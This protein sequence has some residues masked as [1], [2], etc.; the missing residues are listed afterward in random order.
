MTVDMKTK[1]QCSGCSACV[2]ICPKHCISMLPDNEGFIYPVID[3]EKCVHCGLCKKN[4]PFEDDNKFCTNTH[5]TVLG[6]F[7]KNDEEKRKSSSG[8]IFSL[9]AEV[10]LKQNGIVFGMSL[11]DDCKTAHTISIDNNKEL[12][13]LRG[14]KYFQGEIDDSFINAKK[15]L[16]EGRVVLFSGTPCQIA[17]LYSFLGKKYDNLLTVDVVCHGVPSQLL[18][19]KYIQNDEQNRNS[20]IKSVNFRSKRISWEE[21]GLE[22]TFSDNTIKFETLSHNFYLQ[23]FLKNY[24][25]RHSCYNCKTKL[26]ADITLG[27]LWEGKK[28]F[29]NIFNEKGTSLVLIN[30][31]HGRV[32]FEKIYSNIVY[33]DIDYDNVVRTNP[34]II[35]SVP[36]PSERDSFYIDLHCLPFEQ[37]EKKY[38]SLY[39]KRKKKNYAK[40][41]VY[42]FKRG[43]IKI[44]DTIVTRK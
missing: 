2:N 3:K 4:C 40:L 8:G 23:L 24:C 14:S 11:S 22:E 17:G 7:S 38:K 36:K 27:D 13:K 16:D 10:V 35:S 43:I 21:F 44:R 15:Y 33:A 37:F 25:L 39:S 31:E 9:L 29:S 32:F 5:K 6:A 18:W 28:F 1:D 34:C 12:Y 41:S 26:V 30:S 20:I 42:Y 19:R